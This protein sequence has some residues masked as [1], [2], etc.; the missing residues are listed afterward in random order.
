MASRQSHEIFAIECSPGELCFDARIGGDTKRVWLRTDSD[1]TPNADAVLSACLLPAM[2]FGGTLEL[3][4]PISRRLLRTQRE[5]QAVQEA[6]SRGWEFPDFRLHEVDVLA[7]ERPPPEAIEPNG[8]VAAFF[9]GGVDSWAT[10]L[11]EGDLTD[12][13]FVRGVDLIPESPGNV[14]VADEVEGRLREAAKGL[15]LNFHT[16]ATNLRELADPLA[17]WNAYYGCALTTV[18]LFLAPLFERV[19]IAGDSDHEVQIDSGANRMV[20]QLW[21]TEELEIVD[22]GGRYSR[23]ERLARIAG[24][25]IVQE[26]LR[27]CW[28]N[29]DG[30]YNC[31]RCRKCLMTMVPLEAL[32][33][34]GRISTFPAELDLDAVA[35]LEI[36][37]PVSLCLWEDILDATRAAGRPEL[38]SAVEAVVASGKRALGLPA[39]YRRRNVPGPQPTVRIAVVV[40]VWRQPEFMAAAVES[41][42]AQEIGTGVGVVI[43]NDGCP[44]PATHRIGQT[45]RDAHPDRVAYLRQPNRGLSAARNAGIR[46]A[47]A[48]WPQVE[49]VFPLDADNMLSPN[50]LADLRAVLRARPEAGWA[51][52]A[53]ELFG[54]GSGQWS[55]PEPF[56]AYRQLFDNQCDAG[57]LIRRS[58]F[59][60]G[61]EFDET[62]RDGFEDWEFFLRAALAGFR[63]AQAGPC[64]FRYRQRRR[65]MLTQAQEHSA[66][67]EAGLRQRHSECYTPGAL[68]RREHA[69][70][71]RFALVRCDVGD[72]LLTA[73][74]D[75]EPHR[76]SLD[77]LL[78]PRDTGGGSSPVEAH[79]PAV[80]VLTTAAAI[81]WL[82][83]RGLLAEALLH[84]QIELHNR[85]LV[86]L[87]IDRNPRSARRRWRRRKPPPRPPVAVALRTR[88]LA[89]VAPKGDP[90]RP[91]RILDLHAA[92]GR[93]PD[94]LDQSRLESVVERLAARSRPGEPLVADGSQ[95]QFF[96]HRHL[97]LLE[98]T[99]PLSDAAL[100]AGPGRAKGAKIAA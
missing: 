7:P 8:R 91:D 32:G 96:E 72:L 98:T 86:G 47:F 85:W 6:W 10:V 94:P 39:D 69:E 55:V 84:L 66:E 78:R 82:S 24:H 61:L 54:D 100:G 21:S 65:S 31:G 37:R 58:V 23:M 90:L 12:L 76:L 70:T 45:L 67:I 77:W 2:R 28:H 71:P 11:D 9:S 49:A 42:L 25:P 97:D 93:L 79:V 56:L 20:D 68:A 46:R 95:A 74:C 63:G 48:R 15:G 53:L 60:A 64:G 34:R 13:I 33:A 89:E 27:T 88:M 73:A 19:M 16:V 4:A 92:R 1:L 38:E 57:S 3:P 36:S 75:L 35:A 50:T 14:E 44:D 87:R 18:A 41:A 26:T 51:T 30:A 5:F 59:A 40:P 81:D 99:L 62:M 43:V 29:F 22:A 17:P 52:P 80:T 83:A